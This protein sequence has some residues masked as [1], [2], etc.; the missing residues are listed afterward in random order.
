MDLCRLRP[1]LSRDLETVCHK[2]L[3]KKPLNRYA[4][5]VELREEFA[6]IRRNEPVHAR[7][8]GPMQ[9]M[10]RWARRNRTIAVT[11]LV[12]AVSL[13]LLT[14]IGAYAL[15][16]TNVSLGRAQ[17]A[18]RRKGEALSRAT[19]A[20]KEQRHLAE[21]LRWAKNRSDEALYRS[22][23]ARVAQLR[24]SGDVLSARR[25][26]QQL[27]PT[28]TESGVEYAL[29]KRML[30]P[31]EMTLPDTSIIDIAWNCD[32]QSFYTVT[33]DGRIAR[34]TSDGE[35]TDEIQDQSFPQLI[36]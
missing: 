9:R 16:I 20:E 28:G 21:A 10:L 4:S 27:R 34:W 6:R 7:P 14:S 29:L 30:Y 2:C 15:H 24:S 33:S 22:Q 11:G 32:G 8:I 18:E 13:A 25:L 35:K 3:A 17:S 31:E 26:F 5:V 1:G 12:T 36:A 23:I 19:D